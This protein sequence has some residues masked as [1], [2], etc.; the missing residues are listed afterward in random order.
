MVLLGNVF[1]IV[2]DK[3][4]EVGNEAFPSQCRRRGKK[5]FTSLKNLV[6]V[7]HTCWQM[8]CLLR[9]VKTLSPYKLS[10]D[11]TILDHYLLDNE[12]T[13]A[14][15]SKPIDQGNE[16]IASKLGCIDVR[17]FSDVILDIIN[18][19]RIHWL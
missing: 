2:L 4:P 3:V 6:R 1:G 14:V 9:S 11:D 19:H 8:K 13:G 12:L 7:K 18:N 10:F 17:E 5:Y 16:R 15:L